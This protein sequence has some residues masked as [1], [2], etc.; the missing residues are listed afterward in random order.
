MAIASVLTPHDVPATLNYYAPTGD[1]APYR[2]IHLTPPPGK[3]E[4]NLGD[5]PRPVVINDARGR[6]DE[7]SLDVYGFQ[8]ARHVS[9]EKEFV[10]EEKIRG[11]Y[12]KEIEQ[13]L[14][15]VSGAKKVVIF[16]HTIRSAVSGIWQDSV[17]M[18][19]AAGVTTRRTARSPET[20]PAAQW[21]AP[22]VPAP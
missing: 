3:P 12:Y 18:L 7:F 17:L 2:Y 10:D 21:Y 9:A 20:R 1:E 8:F 16:D 22:S 14:K 19:E 15:D 13:L 11:E 5:D 6:E 4:H